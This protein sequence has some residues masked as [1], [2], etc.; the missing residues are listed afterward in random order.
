[1]WAGSSPACCNIFLACGCTNL[2]S[3][4]I[5]SGGEELA[6]FFIY[7]VH[8]GKDSNHVQTTD[9]ISFYYLNFNC[10]VA[11]YFGQRFGFYTAQATW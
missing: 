4:P 11:S 10:I 3:L 5:L 2:S 6:S 1:M 9:F 7:N 8:D